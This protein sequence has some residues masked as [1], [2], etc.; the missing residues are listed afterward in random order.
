MAIVFRD[1]GKRVGDALRKLLLDEFTGIPTVFVDR[2]NYRSVPYSHFG[3]IPGDAKL[4]QSYQGGSLREY[5]YTI[6]YYLRKPRGTG[7]YKSNVFDL[8]SRK[9][10]RLIRLIDINNKH[11]D[12]DMFFGE[13]DLTFGTI[14]EPFGNV[15]AYRWHNGRVEN[16]DFDP[17][18][19][20]KEDKRDLQ[21]MEAQFLCNVMEIN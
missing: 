1:Y 18:R 4:L 15:I 20:D 3:L 19:T 17:P 6:R 16:I 9:S 14:S 12:A 13:V 2:D 21:I 10:E 11:Q 7:Y 5:E 8:L